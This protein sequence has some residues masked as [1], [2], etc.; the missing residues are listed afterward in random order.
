MKKI[1]FSLVVFLF[2]PTAVFARLPN[3]LQVEQWAYQDIGAYVA[4]N[5]FTGSKKVVVAVIDNGFDSFHPDLRDNL[6]V[7]EKEIRNNGL[8]DD[9]NG[10]VDDYYGWDFFD[11]DNNPRPQTV[12]LTVIERKNKIF[13]HG[14][15][16]AGLIG[17]VGN[18]QWGGT[19]LNW[20]VRLMNLRVVDSSG[21]G[22]LDNLAMAINYAVANGADVINISMVGDEDQ[23]VRRAVERAYQRGVIVVA[24]AGNNMWDLDFSPLYPVCAD[25]F[26]STTMVLGVSAMDETHHLTSFSNAGASCIDITAPGANVSSTEVYSPADGLPN[27]YGGN[28]QGTSFA[29]PIVAGAAA[30]IKGINPSWQAS[31]IYQALLATVHHTPGQ[32]EAVYASLFGKGLLQVDKAVE[33]AWQRRID[34][35]YLKLLEPNTEVTNSAIGDIDGD[36]RDELVVAKGGEV[37][38]YNPATLVLKRKFTVFDVPGGTRVVLMLLDYDRDG[39]LDIAVYAQNSDGPI[40]IWNY[41]IKKVFEYSP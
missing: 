17:A 18:N 7:N 9:N 23:D 33:Y 14:T 35:S 28:W 6:W 30:L 24:A 19:G 36:G 37:E 20:Q 25:A 31:E 21:I 2:L 26:S 27:S 1:L 3:D 32:D 22:G 41:K 29:T 5:Y 4:W 11:N 34:D 10:Y 13:N 12:D 16:V 15:V 39:K 40:R 8:D 38:I